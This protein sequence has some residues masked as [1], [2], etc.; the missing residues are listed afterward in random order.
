MGSNASQSSGAAARIMFIAGED[1]GDLHAS[2]VIKELRELLPGVECFGFGGVRM[3]QAGMRLDENLAQNLPIMGFSQV[4]RNYGKIKA[5]LTQ[6]ESM[7]DT[8]KPDLIVLVD[9]P[10]FNLRVARM[11]RKRNIPVVYYISP[12]VWAWHR[13]R[14]KVIAETVTLMLVIL[15]FEEDL[16]HKAGVAVSY[17]GHPLLDDPTALKPRA[18]VLAGLGMSDAGF[19]VGLIP[20]SRKSE[21]V[22][23]LPV[24]LEAAQRIAREVPGVRFVVPRAGGIPM[25]LL[26]KYLDRFPDVQVTVAEDDLKSVRA[27]MD[28]AVCKS[29]TSTLELALL[30][31]PMIIIYKVSG[32]TY[33]LAKAF[34]KIPWIGLVNIVANESICPELIQHEANPQR[35]ANELLR[36]VRD[37]AMMHTMREHLDRIRVRMG[38]RGASRRAAEAIAG[39]LAKH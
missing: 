5:L 8:C 1:S 39:V 23:H 18:E 38:Q 22:R 32:F 16:Y 14:I 15:P 21:V 7:L 4:V 12:Q 17:V 34:V 13:E 31:I 11:A 35:I 37:P 25:E 10:G 36:Y 6:A 3:E 29:G 33:A 2:R 27:A 19:V 9:Y 30:G 28:F 26:K 20:G 24:M